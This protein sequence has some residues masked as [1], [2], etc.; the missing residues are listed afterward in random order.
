[1][2]FGLYPMQLFLLL[3]RE[4]PSYPVIPSAVIRLRVARSVKNAETSQ[5]VVLPSVPEPAIERGVPIVHL[6]VPLKTLVLQLAA[7]DRGDVRER[8]AQSGQRVVLP[9]AQHDRSVVHQVQPLPVLL[10]VLAVAE[11][12]E[13]VA[14]TLHAD[15]VAVA[16]VPVRGHVRE[17]AL[18]VAPEGHFSFFRVATEH[19]R[20]IERHAALSLRTAL[21]CAPVVHLVTH[22]NRQL[23][24]LVL[25]HL[26]N[27]FDQG[28]PEKLVS[29]ILDHL[30]IVLANK[31]GYILRR[32][33]L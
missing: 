10:S 31:I 4:F 15:A 24:T 12:E 6:S 11:V 33:R 16:P 26:Q 7:V 1:M 28:A 8:Q 20:R 9:P 2:L 13:P 23:L 22:L 30:I 18:A 27:A 25:R 21:L 3:L 5:V 14:V 32:V 19:R 29:T 17:G